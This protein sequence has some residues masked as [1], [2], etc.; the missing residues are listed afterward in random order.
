MAYPTYTLDSFALVALGNA[1]EHLGI[2]EADTTQDNIIKRMINSSS[3]MIENFLDRR[4]LQRTYTEYYDGRGQNRIMLSNWPIVK[5]T[6]L[7]DDSSSTFA[8]TGNKF[9]VAEYEV[10]GDGPNAVGV[11]LLGLRFG[12]GTRNI[13]VIYQGGYS[14]TPNVIIE[15][16]LLHVEFLYTMRNDRRVGVQTKGKNQESITYRGDLPDFVKEMLYPYQRL[17][18][19]LSYQAVHNY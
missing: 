2:T 4:V 7:W 12:N 8:D 6:E 14:S 15:A 3:Q 19:P 11:V 18:V 13:K 1:K 9:D 10:D 17:E 5:P 16:C